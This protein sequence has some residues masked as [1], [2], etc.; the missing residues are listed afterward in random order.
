MWVTIFWLNPECVIEKIK[1]LQ[2]KLIKY[3]V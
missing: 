1:S 3:K 2:V